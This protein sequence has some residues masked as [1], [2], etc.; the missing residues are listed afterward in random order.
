MRLEF[1]LESYVAEP[2]DF[3][4]DIGGPCLHATCH[5]PPNFPFD[6]QN[7]LTETESGDAHQTL[8]F[9]LPPFRTALIQL[10]A[11]VAV[12]QAVINVPPMQSVLFCPIPI[13]VD[14]T[15]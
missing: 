3:W 1:K 15:T 4:M 5:A 8:S 10:R 7:C 6:W 13:I 14:W 11:P 12:P 9:P 2:A